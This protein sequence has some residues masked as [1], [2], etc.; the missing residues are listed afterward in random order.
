MPGVWEARL[1]R[2]VQSR[3]G[4]LAR[5][6]LIYWLRA[7]NYYYWTCGLRSRERPLGLLASALREAP[8]SLWTEKH[9]RRALRGCLNGWE[10]ARAPF[11]C[12]LLVIYRWIERFRQVSWAH[13]GFPSLQTPSDNPTPYTLHPTPY[14]LHPTPY[15]LHPTPHTLHPTPYNLHPTPYTS[16]PTPYT[17]HL[18]GGRWRTGT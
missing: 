12:A 17:L 16:H 3:V 15:T 13:Q 5:S 18:G 8:E 2:L 14:T 10:G 11:A 6:D 9:C 4:Y 1:Q 7:N